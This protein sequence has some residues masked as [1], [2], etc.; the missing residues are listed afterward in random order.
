MTEIEFMKKIGDQNEN[1]VKYYESFETE[2]KFAIIMELCDISLLQL[3]KDINFNSK[4]IYEILNQLNKAFRVMKQF[5][6]VHR[7]LKLANILIKYINKEKNK[8][9]VKLSDYGI[10]KNSKNTQLKTQVGTLNY[11]APEIIEG[12]KNYNDQCDL[13]SIGVII[14]ELYYNK[15]PYTGE[16]IFAIQKQ[17]QKSG[18]LPIKTDDKNLDDLLN[19]LLEKDYK[20][21]INWDEYFNHPFFKKKEDNENKKKITLKEMKEESTQTDIIM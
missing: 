9:I 4:K 12:N 2:E 18:N 16:N 6:I 20:K 17:L 1:S 10:S 14:Y 8:Y 13:W 3:K 15:L 5:G 21:R 11:M 7:D 19:K